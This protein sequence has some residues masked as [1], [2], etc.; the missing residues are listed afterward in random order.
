MMRC[1]VGQVTGVQSALLD[2][3]HRG[4]GYVP[5]SVAWL[6]QAGWS[7]PCANRPS[8]MSCVLHLQPCLEQDLVQGAEPHA[9]PR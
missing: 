3:E 4:I 8:F 9:L 1:P 5:G 6:F 7:A 2:P